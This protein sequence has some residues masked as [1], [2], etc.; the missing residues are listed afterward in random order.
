[1]C[2]IVCM[3]VEGSGMER[4]QQGP[5]PEE[6]KNAIRKSAMNLRATYAKNVEP[7]IANIS[8]QRG[9]HDAKD[10]IDPAHQL[11]KTLERVSKLNPEPHRW[12]DGMERP[13]EIP[14]VYVNSEGEWSKSKLESQDFATPKKFLEAVEQKIMVLQI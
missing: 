8:Q 11:L 4:E 1:M 5:T 7:I 9:E 14:F 13:Q 6:N 12:P 10:F 3:Y 2:Y